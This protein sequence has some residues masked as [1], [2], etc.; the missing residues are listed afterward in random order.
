MSVDPTAPY[1]DQNVFAKILGGEPLPDR[2][3]ETAKRVHARG[4]GKRRL[5]VNPASCRR[6]AGASRRGAQ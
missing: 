5:R 3:F 1:D 6:P 2:G 4:M